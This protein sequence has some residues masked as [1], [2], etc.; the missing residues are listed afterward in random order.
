MG[1][2]N[3]ILIQTS[4]NVGPLKAGMQ[5][6]AAAVDTSTKQMSASFAEA[7]ASAEASS[8]RTTRSVTEASRRIRL[9]AE[10]AGI[11]VNRELGRILAQ[12]EM[13][14]PALNAA[15]TAFAAVAFIGIATQ[16][17]EKTS[18]WVADTFIYTEQMKKAYEETVRF[19]NA[20][21]KLQ[22]D[23]S[24][25]HEKEIAQ[26]HQLALIGKTPLEAAQ[27][28]AEWAKEALVSTQETARA[29]QDKVRADQEEIRGLVQ[30]RALEQAKPQ[31]EVFAAG[32]SVTVVDTEAARN[33]VA[34][35]AQIDKLTAA[36][37]DDKNAATAA[38]EG[39]KGVTIATNEAAIAAKQAV[40][41]FR[42][43][44]GGFD[45]ANL[46]ASQE[47]LAKLLA[48]PDMGKSLAGIQAMQGT[49]SQLDLSLMQ[50]EA[51]ATD[52]WKAM[53]DRAEEAYKKIQIAGEVTLRK[54]I[55]MAKDA[56]KNADAQLE[57]QLHAGAI[58]N[59]QLVRAKLASLAAE[60]TAEIAALEQRLNTLGPLEIKQ[61]QTIDGELERLRK[62]HE[63][64]V[65]QIEQTAAVQRAARLRQ[66]LNQSTALFNQGFQSWLSGN[67][68]FSQAMMKAWDQ[69]AQRF[70]MNLLKM[71]EQEAVAAMTH[72][73]AAS[74]EILVDAKAG[75]GKA[76][77]AMVGIPIIGP[78]LGAI[79][80]ALTFAGI[81]A[82]AS[83]DKGGVMPDTGAAMLHRNEMVL[84][85]S[86][87]AVVQRAAKDGGPGG[88]GGGDTHL[89]LGV[90]AFDGASVQKM[91]Q[92]HSGTIGRE[93]R[94]M[95]RGGG[96][97]AGGGRQR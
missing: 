26:Q 85:P 36:M 78:E 71:A 43:L 53:G 6:A 89:H 91:L 1:S 97:K 83:F 38:M 57:L 25:A 31:E 12:S 82:F 41:D 70:V 9:E 30:K 63:D 68:K 46:K 73:T 24:A 55:E 16:I 80:A 93:L 34:L 32:E 48:P 62:E 17:A 59:D 77:R 52:A 40:E 92:Q 65:S 60:Q 75:A 84:D 7:A 64:T 50:T 35:T 15:F 3:P 76:Y 39:T 5:E 10:T 54:T 11:H 42:R 66:D 51:A 23:L 90:T 88:A 94:G 37:M 19:S 58:T 4:V 2:T 79:A 74:R 95:M 47:A 96:L 8:A 13:I 86:L 33:V 14:G 61:R 67:E 69:M 18:Q 22:T 44:H 81:M 45:P 72:K 20:S 29:A 87:S 49:M 21:L 56:E 27:I 28:R